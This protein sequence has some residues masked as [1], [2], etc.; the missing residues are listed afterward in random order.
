MWHAANDADVNTVNSC[1]P[2]ASFCQFS[3]IF[4]HSSPLSSKIVQ[5]PNPVHTLPN[6]P[7]FIK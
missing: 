4:T 2:L 7:Y 6:L 5:K 3:A 1:F